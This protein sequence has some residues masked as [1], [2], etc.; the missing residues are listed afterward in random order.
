MKPTI[1]APFLSLAALAACN[2]LNSPINNQP[3]APTFTVIRAQGDSAALADTLNRFRAALG[4]NLNA[5]NSPP[6]KSGRREINWDG[7]PAA[8]TNV[9]TFPATFF[10]V[11]SKRGALFS[12]PGTGFRVDITA[13]AS[14]NPGLADQFKAFSPKKLFMAVGSGRVFRRERRRD[15]Q[16]PSSGPARRPGVQ[17]RRRGIRLPDRRPGPDHQQ[18]RRFERDQHRCERGR[19]HRPRRDG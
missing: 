5:P 19:H 7:V 16:R 8:L 12:G 18:R 14:I 13:F 6:A 9:D 15:R 3:P 10:N 17:L 2:S 11:T 4:G 1:Y